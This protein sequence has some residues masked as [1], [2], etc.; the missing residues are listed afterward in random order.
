MTQKNYKSDFD[1]IIRL[2]DGKDPE[3]KKTVP[4]PGFDWDVVFW[5]SSKANTYMA[6]CRAGVYTNCFPTG[7]GGMH[8]VFNNHR[9]GPG[10]LQWEPHFELP[11]DIY[12]DD[13]QDLFSRQPL[14]IE[15]VT[16]AGFCPS[17]AEVEAMLPYI[18]GDKGDKGDRG[19]RGPEGPQG[20]QGEVGP[21]GPVG[22][23]GE[24]GEAFTYE[25]FTP[26]QIAELQKPAVA[27]ATRADEAAANAQKVADDY[28][29]E[30]DSKADREELSP[31]VG[32][33]TEGELEALDPTLVSTA[34]R[35]V[36][37]ALTPE[38]QAQVKENIGVSKLELF[39]D[40]WNQAWKING[41]EYGRYDPDNAP[42][43]QH[44]FMGNK[45]WMTC[46]EAMESYRCSSN[47]GD[48]ANYAVTLLHG[49]MRTNIPIVS[50]TLGATIAQSGCKKIEV[51][52]PTS[53]HRMGTI[54]LKRWAI[55]AM[56]KLK[57][58]VGTLRIGALEGN[59]FDQLPLLEEM[60][61][62]GLKTNL[63]LGSSPLLSLHSFQ[64][65]I[66]NA[67]NTSPITITVHPDV[68]AKL[69]DEA[70][71]GWHQVLV[72]AAARNITF[73]TA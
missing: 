49:D 24:R 61:L 25:D 12:P 18:K 40:M 1:C 52:A 33:P 27:A 58:I 3:G 8:F 38:E 5:T 48:T 7:D 32:E 11:N 56:P 55:S 15:L 37:Q 43:P 21:M 63:F 41:V 51:L 19:E 73:A 71:T 69:T 6:S 46:E 53:T 65:M 44:P 39:I 29:D 70:N 2:K 23:Q 45:I 17:T 22:P 66:T 67:A 14:G 59:N 10:V 16:G 54:N 35:K 47:F 20:P 9:L 60:E 57:K 30:L 62:D 42:D 68:Y 13:M 36:P 26:Q 4:W 28:A 72:D 64:Y 31:I 50:F 34:L